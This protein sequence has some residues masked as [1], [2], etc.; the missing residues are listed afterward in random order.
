MWYSIVAM[1][2]VLMFFCFLFFL[3]SSGYVVL[4]SCTANCGTSSI[5]LMS[6]MAA[7]FVGFATTTN[8]SFGVFIINAKESSFSS[9]CLVSSNAFQAV[10][11][12]DAGFIQI[13]K[14]FRLKVTPTEE[15]DGP[16][17]VHCVSICCLFRVVV[18]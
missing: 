14:G 18:V 8:V 5:F 10:T 17:N 12:A 16:E 7:G 3:F 6:Q 9:F 4:R 2:A 15:A 13:Q 11:S 1:C